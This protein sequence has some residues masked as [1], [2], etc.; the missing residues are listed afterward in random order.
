MNKN[1]AVISLSLDRC[2]QASGTRLYELSGN[3]T[4]NLL[5][6]AAVYSQLKNAELIEG[7]ENPEKLPDMYDRICIPAAN[8]IYPKFEFGWLADILEKARM[9]V[10]C[11]GLGTQIDET[12]VEMLTSGTLRFL[13]VL[14]DQSTSIGVR[15]ALTAE[16]LNG[17][18]IKNVEVLGCPSLFQSFQIPEIK[19]VSF[20]DFGTV[21]GSFTR[22]ALAPKKEEVHQQSLA[23]FL[24]EFADKIY[25]QSEI[26][27]IKYL[28]G[29][30]GLHNG[31]ANFYGRSAR[32]VGQTL[33]NKGRCLNSLE[34]WLQ[35]LQDCSAFYTSRIHGC[36]AAILAGC[37][38]LLLTHDLRTRELAESMALANLPIEQ[39]NLGLFKDPHWY[40]DKVAIYKEVRA[41]WIRNRKRLIDFY[42]QNEM[43]INSFER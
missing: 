35:D 9:P 38:A 6:T 30:S 16:L 4:G 1:T 31:L 7:Q 24:F 11:V 12:Q 36:V 40:S 10:C 14:S 34:A 2:A 19:T 26:E 15:G 39:A 23:R 5:F 27:E 25:F 22:F 32:I 13:N 43:P 33:I 18:G 21:G 20:D 8:W 17:L 3:N 42:K 28:A 29:E 41:L 37:P